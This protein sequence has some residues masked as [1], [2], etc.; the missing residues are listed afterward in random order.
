MTPWD[1]ARGREVGGQVRV[2]LAAR[3]LPSLEGEEERE[4][5]V[6]WGESP[7][8]GARGGRRGLDQAVRRT[9][10][11]LPW[12]RGPGGGWERKDEE[13]PYILE[14]PTTYFFKA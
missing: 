6:E 13:A 8:D 1:G 4:G 11:C 5:R 2:Y 3:P 7:W 9:S 10:H 14:D 12:G